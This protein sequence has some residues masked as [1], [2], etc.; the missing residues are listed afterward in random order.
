M[1]DHA[2]K[3]WSTDHVNELKDKLLVCYEY[4]E[5]T[6]K[7]NFKGSPVVAATVSCN[8]RLHLT[9][10][11]LTL[12]PHQVIYMDTDSIVYSIEKEG[13]VEIETGDGLGQW[14]NEI[15]KYGPGV[16]IVGFAS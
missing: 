3:V 14:Q 16:E 2:I 8:G 10:T 11:L 15:D 7:A 1:N 5:Q 12:R 9:S 6:H 13:D 4:I